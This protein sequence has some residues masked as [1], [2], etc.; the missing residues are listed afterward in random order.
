MRRKLTAAENV[1]EYILK[2]LE[3]KKIKEGDRIPPA[4][5][6]AVKR[7]VSFIKAQHAIDS[8]CMDGILETIPRSG[9]FVKV[10]WN[11]RRLRNSIF[12]V[13]R[14]SRQ[15]LGLEKIIR[16]EIPELRINQ[17][18]IRGDFEIDVTLNMQSNHNEYMDLSEVFDELYPDKSI[19]YSK[20]FES[21]RKGRKLFAIPLI[22]SP[23]VICFN[24]DML[25]NAGCGIPDKDWT[26][27]DFMSAVKKLKKKYKPE[28]IYSY[29]PFSGPN[30][31]MGYVF[32]AGGG[33]IDK[34]GRLIINSDKSRKGLLLYK[35]LLNELDYKNYGKPASFKEGNLA[36]SFS[37]RQDFMPQA[38]SL[39]F[40]WSNAPLPLIDGGMNVTAQTTEGL[41]IHKSCADLKLVRR[42]VKV[43]LSEKF[44]NCFAKN[45]YG[46]PIRKDVAEKSIQRDEDP[47]DKL[48][49]DEIANMSAA[50]SVDSPEILKWLRS[51]INGLLQKEDAEFDEALDELYIFF[52]NYMEIE[53]YEKKMFETI[54]PELYK[55]SD[56]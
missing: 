55:K 33:F 51:G 29:S 6:I 12:I 39:K 38:S 23:R 41:C 36:F 34:N 28:N 37:P 20:P 26:W 25:E 11:E 7:K 50:Y 35:S 8:L 15:F 56:Q 5:E 10:G 9:T 49:F 17:G 18:N 27:D 32:R 45:K 16:A 40:N 44:Q 4:R 47:K 3:S 24:S 14:K 31:T 1:R 13:G 22:F 2:L 46:I 54:N 42:V 53:K 21:F 19:F 52:K 48:F 30:M 43:M